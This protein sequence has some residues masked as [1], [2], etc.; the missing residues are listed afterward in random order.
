M[1]ILKFFLCFLDFEEI[2]LVLSYWYLVY[3]V[4]RWLMLLDSLYQNS[5]SAT[6]VLEVDLDVLTTSNISK[7][8]TI[9]VYYY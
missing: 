3:A 1:D 4:S 5:A 2:Y 7:S 8:E 9:L 6:F